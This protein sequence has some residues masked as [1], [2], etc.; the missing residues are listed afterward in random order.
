MGEE[1]H[2]SRE[3]S[4]AHAQS[5][6]QARCF[7]PDSFKMTKRHVLAPESSPKRDVSRETSRYTGPKPSS[8]PPDTLSLPLDKGF[9][10]FT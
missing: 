7:A 6:P 8:D 1:L 4:I 2:V 10:R 3:T 9:D 5:S